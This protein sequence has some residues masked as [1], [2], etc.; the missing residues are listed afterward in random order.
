E[1]AV[2]AILVAVGFAP[3]IEA[4]NLPAAGVVVEEGAI[5]VD[6][7]LRTSV[8]HIWAVGDA[9]GGY[10]FTHVAYE[11]GRLAAHNAFAEQPRPFDDRA[12]PWVTYTSPELA[13][14]GR[15]EQQLR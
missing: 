15:T 5:K 9:V 10:Q 3:A 8:P 11:Q 1:L 12:I 14:V 2:D 6:A 4:L 13:H 7:T